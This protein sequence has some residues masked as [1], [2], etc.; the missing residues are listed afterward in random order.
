MREVPIIQF[1]RPSGDQRALACDVSDET[2]ERYEK[3]LA[4]LNVRITAECILPTS[5]VSLCLE[6]PIYGDFACVLAENLPDHPE[7]VREA[8]EA[9]IW[10]FDAEEFKSW[11]AGIEDDA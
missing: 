7:I 1:L 4:P 11:K 3:V 10:R 5:M 6:E 9:M 2:A 8:L